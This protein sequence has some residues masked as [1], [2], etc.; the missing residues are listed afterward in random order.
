MSAEQLLSLPSICVTFQLGIAFVVTVVAR[1]ALLPPSL[2]I[3]KD[4][5]VSVQPVQCNRCKVKLNSECAA[6]R[7]MG[8]HVTHR[9]M[10]RVN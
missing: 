6:V 8:C 1:V 10:V 7:C 2:K 3:L 5:W 4:V 9:E